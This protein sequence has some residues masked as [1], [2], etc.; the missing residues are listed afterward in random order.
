MAEAFTTTT[1][2]VAVADHY[3]WYHLGKALEGLT[4]ILPS[5]RIG[6]RDCRGGWPQIM[7]LLEK[8]EKK[9]A[10]LQDRINRS[11]Y[12]MHSFR[13]FEVDMDIL[14]EWV[15]L[16]RQIRYTPSIGKKKA[17]DMLREH[18]LLNL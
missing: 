2:V 7:K 12:T 16:L 18:G 5:L 13:V 11:N 3:S 1:G 17:H 15:D 9:H 8:A 4:F 10:D 6:L 14:M